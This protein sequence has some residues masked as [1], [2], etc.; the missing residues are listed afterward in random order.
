MYLGELLTKIVAAGMIAAV[1]DTRDRQQYRLKYHLVR[2]DGVGDW[3]KAIDEVLTGVPAQYLIDSIT[4]EGN[5]ANQLTQRV[6][7]GDW[8]YDST[9]LLLGCLRHCKEIT[10]C[11]RWPRHSVAGA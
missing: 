2:S 3:G 7:S 5:E 11:F 10:P 6:A 4:G 9:A 8:Q 1:D